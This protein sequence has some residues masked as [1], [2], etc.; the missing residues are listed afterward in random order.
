MVLWFHL[1]K[2]QE[3]AELI[4]GDERQSTGYLWGRVDWKG[5]EEA[6]DLLKSFQILI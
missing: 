4:Y 3:K 2:V 1:Y 6:C 5:H